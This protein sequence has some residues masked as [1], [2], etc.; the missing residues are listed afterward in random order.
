MVAKRGLP[1]RQSRWCCEVIKEAG[2]DGR[3]VILGIRR[4]ESSKR[5]RQ[6]Y[7]EHRTRRRTKI[8]KTLIRP[9]LNFDNYD[10]WQYIRE[11]NLP[12][13][14]LYDEGFERL[15]CVLCPFSRKTKQEIEYF[16]KIAA[17]WRRA[18]D[19]IVQRWQEKG[20]PGKHTGKTGQELF[21]WWIAR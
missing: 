21:D 3:V 15:G 8:T 5:N 18:C 20:T 10:I 2:G 11:N 14:S 6:C 4:A 16:P 17:C 7:I 12:Y 1:F 19:H 13:C 9:I